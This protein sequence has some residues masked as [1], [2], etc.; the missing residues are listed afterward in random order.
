MLDPIGAGLVP[1]SAQAIAIEG[2]TTGGVRDNSVTV[3]PAGKPKPALATVLSARSDGAS[4]Q[5]LVPLGANLKISVAQVGRLAYSSISV[6][7]YTMADGGLTVLP[8][9][10]VVRETAMAAGQVVRPVVLGRAG[11][12]ASGVAGVV[13][14][15]VTR[16]AFGGSVTVWK[17]GL[18]PAGAAQVHF[19]SV[20][21][22]G[23]VTVRSGRVAGWRSRRRRRRRC[24][25]ML[26]GTWTGPGRSLCRTSPSRS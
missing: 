1:A 16:A 4:W 23:Q 26:W 10:P 15:V 24:G 22:S 19:G 11:V 20:P 3:W 12:P 13:L 8:Q 5:A 9:R 25:L 2:R 14:N 6:T 17:D 18:S 7:G 21:T